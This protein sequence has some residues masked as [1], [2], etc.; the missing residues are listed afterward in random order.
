MTFAFEGAREDRAK[1]SM[2]IVRLLS[3]VA[4]MLLIMAVASGGVVAQTPS[5]TP[6]RRVLVL[7][8]DERLVLFNII[9]DEAIRA[10]FAADTSH[11]I[12]FH[13]E[14]LDVTRFPG[15]SMQT[16]QTAAGCYSGERCAVQRVRRPAG[17]T[18]WW[19]ESSRALPMN[20][21]E[22]AL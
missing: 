6:L 15:E 3:L 20:A 19:P 10:T 8:S 5:S 1:P 12:E 7:Y 4:T 21:G 14:F 2:W 11:R 13:S 18:Y 16:T 9:L 17:R 22:F